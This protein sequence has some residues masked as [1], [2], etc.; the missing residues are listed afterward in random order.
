[1][2]ATIDDLAH[3]HRV[4]AQ[5]YHRMAEAGILHE[6]DRV[7]LI[8]GEIIDL[9]PIG[10]RHAACV[11]YLNQ[12]LLPALIGEAI[13]RIQ[14]PIVLGESSEPEP[15]IALVR[16]RGD[17]YGSAHPGA[18]DV[19]LIIEVA[20][21]SLRYDREVKIPLYARHAVAEV[22]L[23]DL[24]ARALRVFRGPT[25]QGYVE[26]SEVRDPSAV[27]ALDAPG[28]NLDLSALFDL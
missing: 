19:L 1:M 4:T 26:G 21:T 6:E 23:V 13:V 27:R 22:W 28:L 15:D 20:D 3:R 16:H 7:E 14:Q 2:S 5:Q 12:L 8:E 11:D 18:P 24:E 17:F 10:S 25:A 9:T